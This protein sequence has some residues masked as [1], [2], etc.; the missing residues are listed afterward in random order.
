MI[1]FK[2]MIHSDKGTLTSVEIKTRKI[3]Q[4]DFQRGQGGRKQTCKSLR[5]PMKEF[6]TLK[7]SSRWG[8]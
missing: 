6:G 3:P 2:G 7:L 5:T 1:Q 8:R 4:E